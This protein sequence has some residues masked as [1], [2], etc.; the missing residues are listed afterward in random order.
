MRPLTVELFADV[1]SSDF[2]ESVPLIL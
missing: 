1:S 2:A